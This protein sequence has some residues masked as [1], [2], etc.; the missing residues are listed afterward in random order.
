[1]RICPLCGQT[2]RARRCPNDGS[3]TFRRVSASQGEIAANALI[4]GRYQMTGLLGKGGFGTVYSAEDRRTGQAL[5][6]KV[7][8]R[9]FSEGSVDTVRRFVQEAAITSRLTHGNT[10]R[11]FDYGQTSAGE[12]F[13]VME[14]LHGQTL[15][16]RIEALGAAGKML[17]IAEVVRTGSGV[18]QSLAEAHTNGLVH[19]DLKP[20]NIFL[21]RIAGRAPVVKVL[22]FGVVKQ[23]GKGMTQAGELVGTPAFMSPEQVCERALDGRSDLYSL[24]VVLYQCVAGTLPFEDTN[25]LQLLMMHVNEPPPPLAQRAP[26]APK[27]LI[28]LIE[29]AMAKEPD[30]RWP[31]A[32]TMRQALLQV[33]GAG[34]RRGGGKA[35]GVA[36]GVA[37]D[38][39]AD[40]A[41]TDP[42]IRAAR[43]QPRAPAEV[44]ETHRRRVKRRRKLHFAETQPVPADLKDAADQAEAEIAAAKGEERG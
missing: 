5:A 14:Q 23:P 42:A 31:D 29:R 37:A 15:R 13:L 21:H 22:D 32:P 28:A 36:A 7:L 44:L 2:T 43:R 1:M 11:V 25:I 33:P 4:D 8:S 24:G 41:A 3:D 12:L 26:D 9:A 40:R 10:I 16:H 39:A 19:R 38:R 34:K 18:L 6:V 30:E 17:P 27:E 35:A 20:E